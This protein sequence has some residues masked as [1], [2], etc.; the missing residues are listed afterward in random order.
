MVIA[1]A[2]FFICVLRQQ[3]GGTLNIEAAHSFKNFCPSTKSHGITSRNTVIFIVTATGT[4]IFVDIVMKNELP[5]K[6]FTF[7]IIRKERAMD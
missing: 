6:N 2:K 3:N 4:L 5:A 1:E 7:V